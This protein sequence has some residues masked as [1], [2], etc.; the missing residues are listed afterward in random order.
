MPR[1]FISKHKN[2]VQ[3]SENKKNLSSILL[4]R[5][6]RTIFSYYPNLT[7]SLFLYLKSDKNPIIPLTYLFTEKKPISF[8][9]HLNAL[10][11]DYL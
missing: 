3:L 8:H 2:T 4:P 7:K 11:S 10:Y 5:F 1:L 9:N 6:S